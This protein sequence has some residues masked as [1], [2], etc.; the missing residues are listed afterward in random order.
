MCFVESLLTARPAGGWEAEGR[1]GT[2]GSLLAAIASGGKPTVAGRTVQDRSLGDTGGD[3]MTERLLF[4][5]EGLEVEM[6]REGGRQS[7]DVGG[8]CAGGDMGEGEGCMR[9]SDS[10]GL[11]AGETTEETEEADE[12]DEVDEVEEAEEAEGTEETVEADWQREADD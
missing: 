3:I 5:V 1:G 2:E 10:A 12:V 9:G 7:E 8:G 6:G 11:R 4:V